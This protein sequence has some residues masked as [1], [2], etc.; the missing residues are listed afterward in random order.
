MAK[1]MEL[2]K[3]I[4]R[5]RELDV[6]GVKISVLTLEKSIEFK[7]MKSFQKDLIE[8]M[9]KMDVMNDILVE[10]IKG[11][12]EGRVEKTVLGKVKGS[13]ALAKWPTKLLRVAV[14]SENL[15][16][17]N[18]NEMNWKEAPKDT[19]VYEGDVKGN[20]KTLLLHT[21]DGTYIL[22]KETVQEKGKKGQSGSESSNEEEGEE[23][24]GKGSNA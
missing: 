16:E 6:N 3:R 7:D 24:V 8:T 12:S 21:E 1:K 19:Y 23:G 14:S 4:Y 13:Y 2:R 17:A 22:F 9:E 18:V 5:V 11:S 10:Y 20:F 15:T